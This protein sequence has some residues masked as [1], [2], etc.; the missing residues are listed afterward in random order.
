MSLDLACSP[1]YRDMYPSGHCHGLTLCKDQESHASWPGGRDVIAHGWQL[2][3]SGPV[4]ERQQHLARSVY[5]S[6]VYTS[7]VLAQMTQH[8][9]SVISLICELAW[10]WQS[11]VQHLG[12]EGTLLTRDNR[13]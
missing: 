6:S 2:C 7:N 11:H 10:G 8:V 13:C 3:G 9:F 4:K 5:I 12:R 1:A